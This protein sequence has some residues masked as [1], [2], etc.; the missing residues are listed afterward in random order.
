MSQQ[1]YALEIVLEAG[2]SGA[3]SISTP[4]EPNHKLAKSTSAFRDMPDRYR[5]LVAS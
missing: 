4:I 2:L 1:K 5:R 3:K